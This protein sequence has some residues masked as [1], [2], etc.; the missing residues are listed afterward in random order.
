MTSR[1]LRLKPY[2]D[3]G[4]VHRGLQRTGLQVPLLTF[5]CWDTGVSS[6]ISDSAM[7]YEPEICVPKCW[8]LESTGGEKR[9]EARRP[10]VNDVKDWSKEANECSRL[11]TDG[12]SGERWY[13][14]WFLTLSHEDE[15]KQEYCWRP[16]VGPG[17]PSSP[18]SV[19]FFIFSLFYFLAFTFAIGYRPSVCLSSVC[20]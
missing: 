3:W 15:N 8:K 2:R 17:H 19:Y 10:W 1:H 13:M 11:A 16:R 12:N 4:L 18:L 6:S 14:K 7:W 5:V 20:L 9:R